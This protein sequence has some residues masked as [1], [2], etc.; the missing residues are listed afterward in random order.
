MDGSFICQPTLFFRKSILDKVGYLDTSLKL[1][2][3]FDW[4]IRFFKTIPNEIGFIDETLA[5]SRI[6]ANCLTKMQRKTVAVEGLRVLKRHFD[7]APSTWAWNYIDE[8]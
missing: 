3:D 2:F 7:D 1:S 6:H 8:S 4:W 5:Y